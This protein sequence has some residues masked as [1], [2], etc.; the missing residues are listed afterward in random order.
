MTII[1]F[2]RCDVTMHS[3]LWRLFLHCQNSGL[4]R[5]TH[6]V[7]YIPHSHVAECILFII[8]PQEGNENLTVRCIQ[9]VLYLDL[10][11][12]RT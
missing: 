10:H 6:E 8:S 4:G 9:C 5:F 3:A 2:V 11:T 1:K 7:L 12:D